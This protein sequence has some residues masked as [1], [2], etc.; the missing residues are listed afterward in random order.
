MA[1]QQLFAV[2]LSYRLN[3]IPIRDERDEMRRKELSIQP[4]DDSTNRIPA[5][6]VVLLQYKGTYPVF[7]M[8]V[9]GAFVLPLI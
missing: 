8:S 4:P 9:F 2:G 3:G 6:L 7:F 1:I 5:L